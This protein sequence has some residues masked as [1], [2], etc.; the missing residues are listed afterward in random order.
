MRVVSSIFFFVTFDHK[1]CSKVCLFPDLTAGIYNPF[2]LDEVSGQL[3]VPVMMHSQG[4]GRLPPKLRALI[5][6]S[7]I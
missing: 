6:E 4:S 7:L 3:L 2:L 5:L 1:L